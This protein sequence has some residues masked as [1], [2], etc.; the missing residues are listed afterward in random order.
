MSVVSIDLFIKDSMSDVISV[1]EFTRPCISFIQDRNTKKFDKERA[2]FRSLEQ[3]SYCDPRFG[4]FSRSVAYSSKENRKRM[5][6]IL[7]VY[8]SLN[9]DTCPETIQYPQEEFWQNTTKKFCN[10]PSKSK[11]KKG[12]IKKVINFLSRKFKKK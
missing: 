4:S 6:D 11:K 9:D 3:N 1:P 8:Y 2:S 10:D 5:D 7:S 12:I